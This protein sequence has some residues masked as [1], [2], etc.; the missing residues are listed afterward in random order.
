MVK[1]YKTKN[2]AASIEKFI[3]ENQAKDL[4]VTFRLHGVETYLKTITSKDYERYES[5]IYGYYDDGNKLINVHADIKQYYLLIVSDEKTDEIE[6]KYKIDFSQDNIHPSIIL[7]PNSKI[8]Y[9]N[10][11]P[12]AIYT[13]LL[14]EFNKIKAQN[15]ILV[16]IFDE[17]M[18]GK[19]QA[20]VKFLYEGK[21]Q[22]PIKL[23]LFDGV[24]PEEAQEGRLIRHYLQKQDEKQQ[25]IEVDE[26]E[27]LIEYIKPIRGKKGFDCF[28]NVIDSDLSSKK[29]D[30]QCKTDV[31][32][33]E[34]VEDETIKIYKSR[35]K[36]YIH[37]DEEQ[38]YIDNKIKM[39]KLSRVQEKVAKDESNNIEVIISQNDTNLDSVGEGVNL[40]SETIHINGH[41]GAKSTI[42]ATS[43]VIDGATHQ[44]SYQEAKFAT[45]NRHKGK[46]RCH[47]AKIN[48]LEGGE[49]YAT[50]V[51]INDVLNGVVYA[52]NVTIGRIKNNLKVYAS[53]SI[54]IKSVLGENNIFKINYKDI[55]TLASKYKFLE[56][57]LEHLR[58]KLDGAKKHTPANIPVIT[59]QINELKAKMFKITQSSLEA[60]IS[61]EE[62]FHGVNTIIF[63]LSNGEELVYKTTEKQYEP[64]YL[65]EGSEYITLHPT[66]KKIAIK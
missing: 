5:D 13:M 19:L 50:N 28:G 15:R 66:T 43:L 45:I 1:K 33:I 52:E 38:F 21:F 46:L 59:N 58:Y 53:S 3:S 41:I 23:P 31:N 63:T 48:L 57:D 44:E 42:K 64:F 20:F 17:A 40:T 60:K 29:H 35:R 24:D 25:Y 7:S 47:S 30:L 56:E 37:I 36:G 34:I 49:V 39:S 62:T 61:V 32:S 6:L 51:E 27:I 55:P 8:P 11:K 54:T 14:E 22:K 16:S 4:K 10:Y 18:K 12:K 65:K 26:G 2:I 9:N